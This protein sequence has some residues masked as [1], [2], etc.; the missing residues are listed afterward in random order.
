MK[1][2]DVFDFCPQPEPSSVRLMTFSS[3]IHFDLGI[4]RGEMQIVSL[5][6]SLPQ[7]S[8]AID[9]ESGDKPSIEIYIYMT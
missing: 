1:F 6:V 9:L 5:R 4:T 2:S 3:D 8:G 7:Y